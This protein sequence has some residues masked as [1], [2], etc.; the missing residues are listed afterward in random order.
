MS[1][2]PA[3]GQ[4]A[5]SVSWGDRRVLRGLRR[6][7]L[8]AASAALLLAAALR[9][10]TL[11][12]ADRLLGPGLALRWGALAEE[13]RRSGLAGVAIGA[14]VLAATGLLA[15][16]A[17]EASRHPLPPFR[18]RLPHW[19]PGRQA[20]VGQ[21]VLVPA[22]AGLAGLAAWG[23]RPSAAA[24]LLPAPSDAFLLG[25]VL[26]VAAFPLLIVE[27]SI[28]ALSPRALPEAPALRCLLLLPVL[29]FCAGGI[30]ALLRG[31]GHAWA[32]YGATAID[33]GLALVALELVLRALGRWF[34]PP[35]PRETARAAVESLLA[36]LVAGAAGPRAPGD[37]P[38]AATPLRSHFGLDFSRSWALVFLRRAA[39]PAVVL[40]ALFCWGLSGVAIVPLDARA[41]EESYGAPVAVWGP[42]LHV[43]LPWPLGRTRAVEYGIVHAVAL[44][45]GATAAARAEGAVGAEDPP[46]P[47]DDRLWT[48]THPG[49][50]DYLLAGGARPQ[51]V[52]VISA[53]LR[54]LWRVGMDAAAARRAAYAAADPD[55]LVR[56][57]ASRAA[58]RFFGARTLAAVMDERRETMAAALRADLVRNVAAARAGIE[59]LAVVVEAV[60]PPAGAAD[61][62]HAVQA[63]EIQSRTAVAAERGRAHGTASLAHEEAHALTDTASGAAAERVGTAR[64]DALRFAA[65]RDAYAAGGRA[66]LLERYDTDLIA[67]LART[68]LTIIDQHLSGSDA[69]ALDLR[70]PSALVLPPAGPVDPD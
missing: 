40:T 9:F 55:A 19:S 33:G 25:G 65:D 41:I 61:A 59:I 10:P 34:L 31:A 4:S 20:R 6:L 68:P 46:G 5:A 36:M 18:R 27:R 44:G 21:G 64:A 39:L 62:Y 16:A 8:L 58:A 37:G 43:G 12:L 22:L 54:V 29:A 52:Q 14:L 50:A 17:M 53:D 13:A 42:G 38:G 30:V 56:A 1:D 63:A 2:P 28:G 32:A 47:G 24:A 48:G 3:V 26:I 57:E 11:A 7:G 49:E 70:P 51:D 45:P 69:P 23:L 15:C 66:F 60:H 35:P 67:A